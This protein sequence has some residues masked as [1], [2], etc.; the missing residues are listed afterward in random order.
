MRSEVRDTRTDSRRYRTRKLFCSARWK[1]LAV[2]E[3]GF[4]AVENF[5]EQRNWLEAVER[6]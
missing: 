6:D 2:D 3:T 1:S 4:E 5:P